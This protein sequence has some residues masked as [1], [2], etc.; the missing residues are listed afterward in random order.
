MKEDILNFFQQTQYRARL[1]ASLIGLS[2]FFV[3][4]PSMAG[5]GST[6]IVITN[7]TQDICRLV[8]SE[9]KH[10]YFDFVSSAPRYIPSNTTALPIILSQS[11][12]GSELKLRYECGNNHQVTLYNRHDYRMF[13]TGQVEAKVL[14]ASNLIAE[15]DTTPGSCL[16]NEHASIQWLLR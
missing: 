8:K 11:F 2:L 16:W 7:A 13:F 3:V 9:L 1:F 5:C 10:G 4:T 12:Y 15:F 6:N 14:D